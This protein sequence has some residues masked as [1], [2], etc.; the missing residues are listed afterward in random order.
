M[1]NGQGIGGL[2]PE[3][4]SFNRYQ[5]TTFRIWKYLI[6]M[7]KNIVTGP[8]MGKMGIHRDWPRILW[9]KYQV[10]TGGPQPLESISVCVWPIQ[11][12]FS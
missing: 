9:H 10:S 4:K 3:Y 1:G 8:S 2:I 7:S 6:G 11:L 5:G 12:H